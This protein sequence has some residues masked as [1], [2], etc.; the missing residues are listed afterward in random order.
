MSDQNYVIGQF[1][2]G[3][4]NTHQ[5][6]AGGEFCLFCKYRQEDECSS[7]NDGIADL[8]AKIR[9]MLREKKERVEIVRLVHQEYQEFRPEIQW[10]NHRGQ[11]EIG[12]E[13][14]MTSIERH[15]VF[16]TE[17]KDFFV[18]EVGNV[19]V[20][21]IEAA[22]RCLFSDDGIVDPKMMDNFKRWTQAYKQ[23]M[24]K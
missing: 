9:I 24:D 10:I 21:A 5:C 4:G 15:L 7:E 1:F 17:F 11:C 13:W 22:S 12:P 19:Y 2:S 6:S 20:N 23:W 3:G 14:T 16:S 8:K 18:N